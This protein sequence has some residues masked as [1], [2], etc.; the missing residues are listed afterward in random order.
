MHPLSDPCQRNAMYSVFPGHL[1][2]H[3]PAVRSAPHTHCM[4]LPDMVCGCRCCCCCCVAAAQVR[5]ERAGAATF[6]SL[7]ELQGK[8]RWGI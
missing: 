1:H 3:K 5:L 6:T 4:V 8:N 7:V 2:C